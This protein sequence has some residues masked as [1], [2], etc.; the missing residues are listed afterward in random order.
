MPWPRL[1]RRRPRRA[2]DLDPL[3]QRLLLVLRQREPAT[4]AVLRAEIEAQRPAVPRD[5]FSALLQLEEQELISRL[6]AENGG[7]GGRRFVR[8]R[9]GRRL[10]GLLPR[11][12]RSPTTFYL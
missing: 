10:T 7:A 1:F 2:I 6:P 3:P 8:S 4:F 12:P 11:E 9:D 5:I